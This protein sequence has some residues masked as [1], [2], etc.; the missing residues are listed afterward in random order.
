MAKVFMAGVLKTNFVLHNIHVQD[1]NKFSNQCAHL[2]F[3][4][5]SPIVTDIIIN[6]SSVKGVVPAILKHATV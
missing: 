6:I 3:S 2:Q 4:T 1:M 5:A